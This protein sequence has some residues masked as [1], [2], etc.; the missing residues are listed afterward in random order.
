MPTESY[1]M[2]IP[3]IGIQKGSIW[4]KYD[5]FF[6]VSFD[7]ADTLP[8]PSNRHARNNE[9]ILLFLPPFRIRRILL[10]YSRG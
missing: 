3:L 2:L 5:H 4:R 7:F 1:K 6:V 10:I 8:Q 9:K